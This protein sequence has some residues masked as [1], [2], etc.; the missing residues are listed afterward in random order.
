MNIIGCFLTAM[1]YIEAKVQYPGK[2]AAV[3]MIRMLAEGAAI[4]RA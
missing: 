1:I 4:R 2:N 3:K